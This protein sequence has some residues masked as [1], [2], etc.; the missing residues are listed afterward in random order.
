M[1]GTSAL[2]GPDWTQWTDVSD[3][4]EGGMR[5]GHANGEAVLV[6]RVGSE[7]FGVGASCTHYGGPL[8]DGILV[9]YEVR[10]PWHHGRFDV[11]TGEPVRA[12]PLGPLSCWNLRRDGTRVRVEGKKEVKPAREP[13][14]APPS[15]V[16]IVGAGPAGLC[17][18]E[19]LR[20]EGY[21]GPVTLVGA[22]DSVPVDR[23]NLSK[24]Y[25]AGHAP[26]EWI[27]LRSE[28]FFREQRIDFRRGVR[29][30]AIRV[31]EQQVELSNGSKVPY[32]ALLLTT[33]AQ[34][35]RLT[36]P[37]ADLPHVHVLRT[38][39][40]SRAII[41]AAKQ[42][43]RAVVIGASFIGLEVAASLRARNVE[44]DLVGLEAVPLERV[45]GRELGTFIRGL[46]EEKG[47]RF[48]LGTGV[49]AID[50][51][52]V[53]LENGTTLQA[54]LVVAGVGVRPDTALAE[55]AG[56]KVDRG[57]VV[58]G[59]LQT[60]MPGIY[61]AGDVAR[62][63]EVR[64]GAAARIEHWAVAEEL[65][66]LAA[67]NILGRR[68]R[69]NAAPFFWSQHYDVPINYAGF[70]DRWDE[71]QVYGSIRDRNC[72]VAYR[73]GGKVLAVASIYRDR[74]HLL[75]EDALERGDD[76]AVEQVLRGVAL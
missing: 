56:L 11:R 67:R 55:A 57:I 16:V 49:K 6:A 33:G 76:A 28:D 66:A 39:A 51:R 22:E 52:T 58:D 75:L 48:H 5:V 74:D 32:G 44:V 64:S 45:L 60:S 8:G 63:P 30:T 53:T 23:P 54:D 1:G 9:G 18:A 69:F 41:E 73:R 46:H 36:V 35:V 13:I 68:Q 27:P 4:P 31:K 70:A 71:A 17:A 26:E 2:T 72:V 15:S 42:A 34:P 38:L 21:D 59:Y 10:C 3:L 25:L 43:K 19:T 61:A 7:F 14:A 50:A 20:R 24:D 40:D 65:G 37:G 12:P 47:V 62:F 29:A